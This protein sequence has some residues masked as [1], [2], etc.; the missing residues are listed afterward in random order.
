MTF[1]RAQWGSHKKTP[2]H[3]QVRAFDNTTQTL[4]REIV[5]SSLNLARAQRLARLRQ[6]ATYK[7]TDQPNTVTFRS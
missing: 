4:P 1:E 3:F 7:S 5:V 6:T 2:A